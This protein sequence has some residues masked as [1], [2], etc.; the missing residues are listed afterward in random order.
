LAASPADE[1]V[2]LPSV[3]C[4]PFRLAQKA[5]PRPGVRT[6]RHPARDGR[7]RPLRGDR[8]NATAALGAGDGRAGWRSRR[9][10]RGRVPDAAAPK[11]APSYG[12][13]RPAHPAVT[14]EGRRLSIQ[15]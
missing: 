8:H 10:P 15:K 12:S 13:G 4:N 5:L 6:S 11:A 7:M 1:W 14:G 2:D 3:S 9:A